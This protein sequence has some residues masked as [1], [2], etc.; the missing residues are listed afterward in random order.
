M[1]WKKKQAERCHSLI[2]TI[3]Y[4]INYVQRT[5]YIF[6]LA[7]FIPVICDKYIK[8]LVQRATNNCWT[9]KKY[10]FILLPT[11]KWELKHSSNQAFL[12][13][14]NPA[15]VTLKCSDRTKTKSN[16]LEWAF[17]FFIYS[18][19]VQQW[20]TATTTTMN[21]SKEKKKCGTK[22]TRRDK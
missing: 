17:S 18:L 5:L 8:W 22:Q 10:C 2:T 19:V 12:K 1:Q 11:H 3:F 21:N 7:F 16:L 6:G 15:R 14:L 13:H 4:T 20:A 9:S